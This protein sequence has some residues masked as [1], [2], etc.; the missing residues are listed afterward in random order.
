MFMDQDV[1]LFALGAA[2]VQFFW[3]I[4]TVVFVLV[5]ADGMLDN[6]YTLIKYSY[7]VAAIIFEAMAVYAC[8]RWWDRF[9]VPEDIPFAI[10]ASMGM[11]AVPYAALRLLD[12]LA[13]QVYLAR[14]YRRAQQ[15]PDPV[16]TATGSGLPAGQD[17]A[18]PGD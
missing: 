6:A 8:L 11:L 7:W 1:L 5:P 14:P 12:Y 18:T 16:G 9:A 2:L 17:A 13:E 15:A 3:I 10:V 4:P